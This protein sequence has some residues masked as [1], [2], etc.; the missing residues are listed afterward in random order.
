MVRLYLF[1][2]LSICLFVCLGQHPPEEWNQ[3]EDLELNFL[4]NNV[5]EGMNYRLIS[6][7]K[8]PPSLAL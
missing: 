6:R 2:C 3:Y 5:I 8:L 1:G 7:Y 4:T